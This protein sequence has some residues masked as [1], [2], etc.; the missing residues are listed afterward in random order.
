MLYS[1]YLTKT[2]GDHA[3]RYFAAKIRKGLYAGSFD[4]PSNGH[5]DII[6]RGITLCDK[7]VIGVATNAMKR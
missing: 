4:P 5:L 2:G 7:L 1:G 6:L 3:K